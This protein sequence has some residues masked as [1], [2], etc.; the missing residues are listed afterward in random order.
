[1]R[2]FV[3]VNF[4][5]RTRARLLALRDELESRSARGNFSLPEN[6]HLTLAFL[7]GCDAEQDAMTRAILGGMIFRPFDVTIDRIGRFRRDGG[8]LWW[9]GVA[10]SKALAEVQRTIT[11][12]LASAGMLAD[13]RKF[14]PHVTLGREVVTNAMPWPIGAFSETVSRLDLM[15]SERIGGRL[16]YTVIYSKEGSG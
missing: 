16:T 2:L 8:D 3:A 11:N 12:Q 5:E 13:R 4:A 15:K 10:E 1:V 6:L 14:S 7:G 9:A